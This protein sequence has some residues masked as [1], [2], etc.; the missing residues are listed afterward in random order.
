MEATGGTGVDVVLNSLSGE[1]IAKSLSV[2]GPQGRFVEIGK[3]DIA[4]GKS[5][6]LAPFANSLSYFAVDIDRI[7]HAR[8]STRRSCSRKRCVRRSR[9]L[10]PVHSTVYPLSDVVTA[11]RDM[12]QAR[13]I[14]KMSYPWIDETVRIQAGR[15]GSAI[16]RPDATYLIT[17]GLGGFG[18]T[19]AKWLVPRGRAP[20]ADE[21]EWARRAHGSPPTS[22]RCEPAGPTSWWPRRTSLRERR[23][24]GR[25]TDQ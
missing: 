22:R 20:G 14:G 15:P 7:L 9:S 10:R 16:V 19:V 6:N 21:Q 17:G 1:A 8:P 5:L 2:L 18:L 3:T 13:H 4:Q 25:R 23:R 24:R 12:A 11:F